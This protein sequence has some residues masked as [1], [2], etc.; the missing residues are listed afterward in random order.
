MDYR[1]LASP[2]FPKL[3]YH[4]NKSVHKR[5]MDDPAN[6][7]QDH[8]NDQ[9]TDVRKNKSHTFHLYWQYLLV[10]H[11]FRQNLHMHSTHVYPYYNVANP[12][13]RYQVT[14]A[15]F[16]SLML[17]ASNPEPLVMLDTFAKN[18]SYQQLDHLLFPQ[19]IKARLL[20]FHRWHRSMSILTLYAFA[21]DNVETITD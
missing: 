10:S 21:Y 3:S 16:G 20:F 2:R 14:K 17:H 19:H 5:V 15:I 1:Y 12:L 6:L 18:L 11:A 13:P 8:T 7:A 4:N 9:M